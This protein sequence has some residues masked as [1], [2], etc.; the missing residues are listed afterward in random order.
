[1]VEFAQAQPVLRAFGAVGPGNRALDTALTRQR[2]AITRRRAA[3]AARVDEIVE[4][5][6]DGYDTA[7]G[8]GG[9]TLSGGERQRVSIA[10]AL[11]EDAPIV[12]L[13]EA[14][15]ALD[16]HS[17]AVVVRGMHELTRDKTVIVVTHPLA[18][19]AHADQILF[20]DGGRIIERGTHAELLALDG[21]YADFWNERS[22]TT[23]WRL[24]PTP[25]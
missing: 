20:L 25:V 4:R 9:A 18:T 6:P 14:T 12:L 2:S 1:M 11:L 13:D 15:S 10:R 19:I 8:E 23:G 5:L 17:E 21:R 3:E 7:V 22:R 16:P 24:E